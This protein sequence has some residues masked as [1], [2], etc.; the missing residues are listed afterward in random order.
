MLIGSVR[1]WSNP[2]VSAALQEGKDVLFD[3]TAP[4][5]MLVLVGVVALLFAILLR[6]ADASKGYGLEV[7]NERK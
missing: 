2:G 7:P 1:E 5:F 6:K 3:Y 4:M